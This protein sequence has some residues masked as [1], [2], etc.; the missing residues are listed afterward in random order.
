MKQLL[1]VRS[2]VDEK[3][4]ECAE[5]RVQLERKRDGALN[6]LGNLLHHSCI[7]SNNEVSLSTI[8]M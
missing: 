4:A 1:K 3:I 8:C 5:R 6:E 7:I 2:L